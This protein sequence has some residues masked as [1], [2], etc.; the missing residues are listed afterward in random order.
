MKCNNTINIVTVV[1]GTMS[2]CDAD[3]EQPAPWLPPWL[4]LVINSSWWPAQPSPA[5]P[6]VTQ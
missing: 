3:Y 6:Y 4:T 2:V 5:Q 1:E